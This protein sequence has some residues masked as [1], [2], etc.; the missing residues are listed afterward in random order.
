MSVPTGRARTLRQSGAVTL[1]GK[2]ALFYEAAPDDPGALIVVTGTAQVMS[3]VALG[4]CTIATAIRTT[5]TNPV[6]GR[7]SEIAYGYV[8]QTP[9]TPETFV[10]MGRLTRP[11]SG[12][13]FASWT[14]TGA[15]FERSVR[16]V[17]L[18]N[19]AAPEEYYDAGSETYFE[20]WVN[21]SL[22][23]RDAGVVGLTSAASLRAYMLLA[24]QVAVSGE[25]TVHIP[26]NELRAPEFFPVPNLSGSASCVMQFSGA[27]QV[28]N[29]SFGT[30]TQQEGEAGWGMAVMDQVPFAHRQGVTF[31]GNWIPKQSL[32]VTLRA[33]RFGQA[34]TLPFDAGISE[35]GNFFGP[36]RYD[37]ITS[38]F[39]EAPRSYYGG[40]LIGSFNRARDGAFAS[41]VNTVPPVGVIRDQS[42]TVR[43]G[44]PWTFY[45][46]TMDDAAARPIQVRGFDGPTSRAN[47]FRCPMTPRGRLMTI[48]Q[49]PQHDLEGGARGWAAAATTTPNAWWHPNTASPAP[50]VV[51]G[52]KSLRFL[53]NVVKDYATTASETPRPV[54]YRHWRVRA[55]CTNRAGSTLQ[56]VFSTVSLEFSWN[57]VPLGAAGEWVEFDLDTWA[58]VAPAP[59]FGAPARV[60]FESDRGLQANPAST[61][62][63]FLSMARLRMTAASSTDTVEVEW[64]RGVRKHETLLTVM[65]ITPSAA[66]DQG[67]ALRLWTDGAAVYSSSQ[68]TP[69]TVRTDAERMTR[70]GLTVT[71]NPAVPGAPTYTDEN[72]RREWVEAAGW[73]QD[74]SLPCFY[75]DIS[76]GG[77]AGAL[78][79]VPGPALMFVYPG[80]GDVQNTGQYGASTNLIWVAGTGAVLVTAVAGARTGNARAPVQG[81]RIS[82]DCIAP[83]GQALPAP[84]VVTTRASGLGILPAPYWPQDV[85]GLNGGTATFRATAPTGSRRVPVT[86]TTPAANEHLIDVQVGA[87]VS[88]WH[89]TFW[90]QWLVPAVATAIVARPLVIDRV[91]SWL[92]MGEEKKIRT[93]H[94]GTGAAVFASAD[95]SDVE[96]WTGFDHDRRGGAL[97][98]VGKRVAGGFGLYQSRDGGRSVA[99]VQT[100][101]TADSSVVVVDSE[102]GKVVWLYEDTANAGKVVRRVGD[103][104]GT[105][106]TWSAAAPV[107]LAGVDLVAAVLSIDRSPIDAGSIVM[108]VQ[109]SGGQT[110]VL[111]SRDLGANWFQ[112]IA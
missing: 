109:D 77:D 15:R 111:K 95:H 34:E 50:Q 85:K 14:V 11:A 59:F 5:A 101:A 33:S 62:P 72:A 17:E 51:D 112:L 104:S 90:R 78:N 44:L 87:S 110:R 9:N 41:G 6:T 73:L 58:A 39:T 4:G 18:H 29:P 10:E 97:W 23:F 79:S 13:E 84:V 71:T 100:M 1:T 99:G 107:K 52:G 7:A 24:P 92:H 63:F 45:G 81:T 46:A 8:Y 26:G 80:C 103:A 30:I 49:A 60:W 47:S 64:V 76:A 66:S 70:M 89:V 91:R 27:S 75:R 2:F 16:L 43:D 86:T 67:A 48:S 93:F 108:S 65:D 83:A 54:G 69:V 32:Q 74:G 56:L 20:F 55:R 35:S 28:Q 21:N 82:T 36:V 22:A 57:A 19:L 40:D 105:G 98:L 53:H 25:N 38:G 106:G 3:S 68:P 37:N 102:R 88:V 12:H 42:F 31:T 61:T 94:L 96:A